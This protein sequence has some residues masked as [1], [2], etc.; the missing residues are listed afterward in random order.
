LLYQLSY[1]VM[2]RELSQKPLQNQNKTFLRDDDL[3]QFLHWIRKLSVILS[4][5]SS[6]LRDPI[7]E[8]L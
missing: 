2:S 5:Q 1:L 7:L 6:G 4:E 3:G 8:A